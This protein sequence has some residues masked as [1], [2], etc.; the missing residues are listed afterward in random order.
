[1]RLSRLG[2]DL[3]WPRLRQL[4]VV[5]LRVG[6]VGVLCERRY[7]KSWCGGLLLSAGI[8]ADR[9]VSANDAAASQCQHQRCAAAMQSWGDCATT[10][11]NS[12]QLSFVRVYFS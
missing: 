9:A 2:V 5:R 11:G 1:M 6:T 7:A 3:P 12:K 4:T 10:D 8:G